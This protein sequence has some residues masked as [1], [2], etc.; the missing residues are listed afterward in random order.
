M[1]KGRIVEQGTHAELME[2]RAIYF[3]MVQQQSVQETTTT[4]AISDGISIQNEFGENAVPGKLL[5]EFDAKPTQTTATTPQG[6]RNP[7]PCSTWNLALFV[8]SLN[9]KDGLLIIL[10]LL[11]SVIAGASHPV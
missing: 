2:L 7:E 9:R 1:C 11:F 3:D 4:M 5:M 6:P 10:G 8:H